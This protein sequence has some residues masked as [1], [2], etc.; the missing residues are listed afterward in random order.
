[1]KLMKFCGG[2]LVFS[3]CCVH[4]CQAPQHFA[5]TEIGYIFLPLILK[6]IILI[7]ITKSLLCTQF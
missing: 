1:M 2:A 4:A 7:R 3:G 6:A 5:K